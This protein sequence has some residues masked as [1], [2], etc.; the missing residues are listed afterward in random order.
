MVSRLE[1]W[2]AIAILVSVDSKQ[3][4]EAGPVGAGFFYAR[5]GRMQPAGGAHR[6]QKS[7]RIKPGPQPLLH[8]RISA[9]VQKPVQYVQPRVYAA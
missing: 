1:K 9:F 7:V 2:M 6:A 5:S 3:S 8:T 4:A